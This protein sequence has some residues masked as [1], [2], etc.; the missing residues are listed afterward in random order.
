V[1]WDEEQLRVQA[2][3]VLDNF[4]LTSL[5]VDRVV[6]EWN[7]AIGFLPENWFDDLPGDFAQNHALAK[8]QEIAIK[9][10]RGRS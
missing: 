2:E 6:K 9:V 4:D 1:T 7:E 5:E 8:L 10:V 3:I